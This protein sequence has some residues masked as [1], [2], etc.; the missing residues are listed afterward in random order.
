MKNMMEYYRLLDYASQILKLMNGNKK[1][2]KQKRY[3][4][5]FIIKANEKGLG[6]GPKCLD[7]AVLLRPDENHP[8]LLLVK[9]EQLKSKI[10]YIECNF[11]R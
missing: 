3:N 4:Y 7:R 6:L 8:D 10:G 1:I 11:D 2:K 5:I 9:K